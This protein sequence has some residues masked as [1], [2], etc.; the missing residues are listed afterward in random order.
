M[1]QS[2]KP[3][4]W[5]YTSHHTTQAPV[6]HTPQ[7]H[8]VPGHH[9]K[10]GADIAR[11][12]GLAKEVIHAIDAHHGDPGPETL[13]AQL[14]QAANLISNARPGASKDNLDSYLRRLMELENMCRTFQGVKSAYAI[15]AGTE[16]KIFV[17]PESLDDLQSIKL[18]HQIARKIEHDLHHPGPVKIHVIRESRV[19]DFAT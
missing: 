1:P 17:N 10:I 4:Y 13:E 11:K 9:S 7:Y 3:W 2:H 16:V 8:E 19:E 6:S 5:P 15:Q 14:V 18:S 12:F